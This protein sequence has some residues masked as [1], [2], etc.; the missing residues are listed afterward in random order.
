MVKE[1]RGTLRQDFKIRLD[2]SNL[3]E[4]IVDNITKEISADLDDVD[5]DDW[6]VDGDELEISGAYSS[7]FKSW[8]CSATLESPAEYDIDRNYIGCVSL[9]CLPEEMRKMIT[10]TDLK[11]EEEDVRYPELSEPDEDY[12]YDCYRDRML[13]DY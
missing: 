9:C 11:E 12:E 7:N 1:G 4:Y 10:V 5:I 6:S 3:L 13:E 8:Y 2:I